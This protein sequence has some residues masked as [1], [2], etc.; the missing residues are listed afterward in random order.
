MAPGSD[1]AVAPF[2][3]PFHSRR[4]ECATRTPVDGDPPRDAGSSTMGVLK[5][6]IAFMAGG[7]IAGAALGI[8]V[9]RAFLPWYNTPGDG[10]HALCDCPQIVQSTVDSFVRYQLTGA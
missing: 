9:G 7:A 2:R 1:A 5:S 6:I 4:R 3:E 8:A 10:A